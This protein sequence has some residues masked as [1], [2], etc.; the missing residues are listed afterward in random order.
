V[1][2]TIKKTIIITTI[3]QTHKTKRDAIT[4]I[5]FNLQRYFAIEQRKYLIAQSIIRRY[6]IKRFC[7]RANI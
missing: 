5:E 7:L 4:I 6:I 1:L 3:K 2:T